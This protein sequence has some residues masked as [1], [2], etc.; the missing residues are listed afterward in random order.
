VVLGRVVVAEEL[1]EHGYVDR[2]GESVEVGCTPLYMVLRVRRKAAIGSAAS[3]RI[4]TAKQCMG[5]GDRKWLGTFIHCH[6]MAER[7]VTSIE[8]ATEAPQLEP[9]SR[10]PCH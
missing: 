6:D 7:Q 3:R 9:K 2:S 8:D 5:N 1:L 10:L 4:G